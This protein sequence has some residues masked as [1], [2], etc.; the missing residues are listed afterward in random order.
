MTD[1]VVVDYGMGN[2]NSVVSAFSQLGVAVEVTSQPIKIASAQALI[3]PGVGAFSAAMKNIRNSGLDK[4]LNERV[5]SS[6]V[7]ILGICLGLQLFSQDSEEN[8][9]TEGLGWI[10]GRVK[11]MSVSDSLPLPHVGWNTLNVSQESTLFEGMPD[12]P[13]FYFDHVYHLDCPVEYVTSR[14]EYG[15]EWV[16]SIRD[17]NIFAAQ[18]HPEKSQRNGLKMLR[19]F[20]NH[21]ISC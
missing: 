12:G 5:L 1:V 13:H 20:L 17:K 14:C 21:A 19:N 3:L 9:Y 4:A 2:L 11:K 16:A 7:P 8:G 18:F 6:R 15:G 10:D